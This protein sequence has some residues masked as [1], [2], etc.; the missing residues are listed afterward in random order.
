MVIEE[1]NGNSVSAFKKDKLKCFAQVLQ[2]ISNRG[3]KVP[4]DLLACVN[5]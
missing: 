3:Y 1:S 2:Y 5:G 4:D